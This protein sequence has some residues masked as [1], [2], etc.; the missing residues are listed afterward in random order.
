VKF[1]QDN[2]SGLRRIAIWSKR[3]AVSALCLLPLSTLAGETSMDI[4]HRLAQVRSSVTSAEVILLSF[5]IA[6]ATRVTENELSRL[7][8]TYKIARP[9]DLANLADVLERADVRP[10]DEDPV[11]DFR[12]GIALNYRDGTKTKLLFEGL[13]RSAER[14]ARGLADGVAVVAAAD[15]PAELRKVVAGMTPASAPSHRDCA[16]P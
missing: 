10:S 4:G 16:E 1:I 11:K 13:P 6:T 14:K 7:G 2:G 9:A 3:T 8:C 12:I 5:N 15:F